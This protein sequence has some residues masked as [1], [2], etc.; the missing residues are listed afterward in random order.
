MYCNIIRWQG[1]HCFCFQVCHEP[2][3]VKPVGLCHHEPPTNNG[4]CFNVFQLLHTRLCTCTE[5]LFNV[6]GSNGG[7]NNIFGLLSPVNRCG[8]ILRR[9]GSSTLPCSCGQTEMRHSN[10]LHLDDLHSFRLSRFL[11]FKS[12][13]SL[14]FLHLQRT[15][16]RKFLHRIDSHSIGEQNQ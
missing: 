2:N 11:Q 14:A 3:R 12:S 1:T 15:K 16:F 9:D 4:R 5:Y 13:K 8:S 6:R 10:P 7:S